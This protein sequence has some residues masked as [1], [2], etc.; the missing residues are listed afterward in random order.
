M[1]MTKEIVQNS[2]MPVSIRQSILTLTYKTGEL[3][4]NYRPISLNN[5]GYKIIAF[6]LTG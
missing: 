3:L 5:Y 2:E 1:D 6:V 4:K